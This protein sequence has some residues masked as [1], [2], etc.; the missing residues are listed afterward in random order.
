MSEPEAEEEEEESEPTLKYQRLGGA[1]TS[2]L[3]SDAASC[4]AAHVKF[5]ALG[6]ASGAVHVLDLSGNEIRRFSPHS[7]VVNDICIDSTGE[8]VASCSQD[9]TVVVSPL[10]GGEASTHWYHRP[11]RAI[12]L[13][14]D[15][16]ARRVFATGGLACQLVVNS[17]GW[18]GSKDN[19]IH[20]GEGPIQALRI[21]GPMLAWANDLGVKVYDAQHAKRVSYIERT[22]GSPPPHLFK[23]H[24]RWESQTELIIGWVDTIKI[25]IVS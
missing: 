13:D 20:S 25:V 23:C 5:I 22:P 8:F 17:R 2:I 12:A 19:P 14:P 16:A 9:G 21:C 4:L 3:A 1:V 15:Y 7:A 18:F 10:F 6:T 11:V 24:L